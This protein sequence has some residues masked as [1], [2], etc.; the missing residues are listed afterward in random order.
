M[1]KRYFAATMALCMSLTPVS[2]AA[3]ASDEE[4]Q[5]TVTDMVAQS[6]NGVQTHDEKKENTATDTVAPYP[7]GEK[8]LLQKSKVQ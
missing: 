2:P 7:D 5:S 8:H 1:K 3:F 6:P 4:A